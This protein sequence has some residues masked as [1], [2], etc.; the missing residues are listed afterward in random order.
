M[1]ELYK[2]KIILK[3][4][5]NFKKI[6]FNIDE[7]NIITITKPDYNLSGAESHV[8]YDYFKGFEKDKKF[9]IDDLRSKNI[10]DRI[11]Y[12][13]FEAILTEMNIIYEK[14]ILDNGAIFG[15]EIN[16]GFIF[17]LLSL[18]DVD[19]EYKT[20]ID[21]THGSISTDLKLRNCFEEC[22]VYLTD[23]KNVTNVEIEKYSK[24]N[25]LEKRKKKLEKLF[26]MNIFKYNI[27]RKEPISII[28]NEKQIKKCVPYYDTTD[29]NEFT[30][31][32]ISKPKVYQKTY[33]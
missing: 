6:K 16:T 32:I 24:K 27:E 26:I 3:R 1:N 9:K 30:S 7:N 5:I 29:L 22:K 17:P 23:E 14:I 20:K 2:G 11:T 18:N 13:Y 15:K 19:L 31:P 12:K 25:K 8:L 28:N 33:K 21:D 10:I 4:N